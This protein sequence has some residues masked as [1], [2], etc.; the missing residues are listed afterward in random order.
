MDFLRFVRFLVVNY[1]LLLLCQCL[2]RKR[3][4]YVHL[5]LKDIHHL[6]VI[7]GENLSVR[8]ALYVLNILIIQ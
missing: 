2:A 4:L 6:Y 3:A 7:I 1:K 8:A 5:A